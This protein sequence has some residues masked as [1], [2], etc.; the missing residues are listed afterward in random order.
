[1]IGLALVA[2]HV[3]PGHAHALGAAGGGGFG[4]SPLRL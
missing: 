2:S 4:L 3:T 1:L